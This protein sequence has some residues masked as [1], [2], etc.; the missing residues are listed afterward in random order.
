MVKKILVTMT[1]TG[2]KAFFDARIDGRMF[3]A[4]IKEGIS[5]WTSERTRRTRKNQLT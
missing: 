4:V 3:R 5:A 1:L 2:A